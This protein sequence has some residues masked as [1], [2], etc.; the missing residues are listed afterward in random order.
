MTTPASPKLSRTTA[1][2]WLLAVLWTGLILWAG[3][4]DY[5]LAKTSRFLL[6]LLHWLLPDADGPTQWQVI[7]AIRKAA[8][9]IEYGVLAWLAWLALFSTYRRALLRYAGLALAW[10]V[11]VAA[12]D[13]FR[14]GLIDSRTGSIVDVAIDLS[15]GVLALA[16]AIA[17]T[18]FMQR[19]RGSV[20]A[21]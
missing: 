13:E 6:P 10:V 9:L 12:F 7:F 21:E 20:A 16:L 5:S 18:R 19:T 4:D 17:Y 2:L 1:A 14:Q 3:S 8:H 11:V 15:G